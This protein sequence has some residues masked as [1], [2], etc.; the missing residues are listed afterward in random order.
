MKGGFMNEI[1]KILVVSTSTSTCKRTIHNGVTLA[2]K[3]GAKLY[4]YHSDFD[5]F[6]LEGWGLPI[7]SLQVVRKDYRQQMEE[8]RTMLNRVI[9]EEKTPD[10][11][12]EIF[13][14]EKPMVSEVSR[15]VHEQKI[16]LLIMTAFEEGRLEH[17]IYGHSTHEIVRTMPCSI[18]LVKEH[19]SWE[20]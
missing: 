13:V 6:N 8:D 14:T 12:L 18:M 1:K 19:H 16:D 20:E 15:I 5:P 10:M 17:F 2:K 9:E 7:P 4:V 3:L 11:Q